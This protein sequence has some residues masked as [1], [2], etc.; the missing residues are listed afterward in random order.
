MKWEKVNIKDIPKRHLFLYEYIPKGYNIIIYGL[1]KLGDSYIKQ[2]EETGYCN[3]LGIS[4]ESIN[5]AE[6]YDYAFLKPKEI[7]GDIETDYIVIAIDDNFTA[8]SLYWRFVKA[9]VNGNLIKNIYLRQDVFPIEEKELDLIK[10]NIELNEANIN[11]IFV[12]VIIKGGIGD[13]IISLSFVRRLLDTDKSILIDVYTDQSMMD[14]VFGNEK[15]IRNIFCGQKVIKEEYDIVFSLRQLIHVDYVTWKKINSIN[16]HLFD[17]LEKTIEKRDRED[18]ND[19]REKD[20]NI[21]KR[22]EIIGSNRYEMLG[23]QSLWNLHPTMSKLSFERTRIEDKQFENLGCY[24]TVNAGS[25]KVSERHNVHQTKEW[26]YENFVDLISIIKK[27][28]PQ[29]KVIQIGGADSTLIKGV[30]KGIF[31]ENL[32]YIKGLLRNAMAHIDTEGGMVHLATQLGTKCIVLFG[33]TPMEYYGYQ[34][35]INIKAGNCHGCMGVTS[36]WH[37]KCPLYECPE[38][39]KKITSK[40]VFDEV[41]K[42]TEA[43]KDGR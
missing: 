11:H 3:I 17:L 1:G 22:A 15:G 38:C 18:L 31:G 5:K 10:K 41:K 27:T 36:D 40:M 39:M 7:S 13:N 4:D 12:A 43:G 21:I 8:S 37:T 16:S 9:G 35:N 24:L 33:P 34:Q 26:A 6:K 30:D 42:I 20:I 25:G 29:I 32:N 28:Y 14:S 2:I 23:D 19:E